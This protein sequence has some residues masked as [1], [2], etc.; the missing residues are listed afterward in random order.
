MSIIWRWM[1]A[2]AG[3]FLVSGLMPCEAQKKQ[4]ASTKAEP[5]F[6][7]SELRYSQVSKLSADQLKGL[8][9][10]VDLDIKGKR[11]KGDLAA[12]TLRRELVDRSQLNA[13]AKLTTIQGKDYETVVIKAGTP[14]V[15]TA[16]S[17]D[18]T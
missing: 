11:P 6:E 7:I 3:I 14:G 15:G 5:D 4:S 17:D 16:V 18:H 10:F 2:V 8:Q 1:A 9:Y 13:S 12:I